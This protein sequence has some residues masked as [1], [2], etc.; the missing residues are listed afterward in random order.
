MNLGKNSNITKAAKNI[1]KKYCL[2]NGITRD[3]VAEDLG[4]VRGTL[5]NKLKPSDVK[6]SLTGEEILRLC[7]I[8]DNDE[9]LKAMCAER[10]LMVFDPI[11]TMPDGGDVLNSTLMSVLNIN[12]ETGNLSKCVHDAVEDENI[13][14]DEAKKIRKT[15]K[16]IRSVARK[17][18]VMLENME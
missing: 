3:E 16:S 5:D 6:I 10:G 12:T 4:I 9:I 7:E 8:T 11:E 18:E 1:I 13:D 2:E 15:L 14:T 17:F